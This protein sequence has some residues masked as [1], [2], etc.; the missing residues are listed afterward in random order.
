MSASEL[1]VYTRHLAENKQE[2]E[3]F[4]IAFWK[5]CSIRWPSSC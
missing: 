3:R 5:S 2:T 1:A 4:K